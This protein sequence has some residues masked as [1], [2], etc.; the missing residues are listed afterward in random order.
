ML[1]GEM[2]SQRPGVPIPLC[3]LCHNAME[4]DPPTRQEPGA[5]GGIDLIADYV[6]RRR[7]CENQPRRTQRVPLK[8]R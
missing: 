3:D 1:G 4:L 5:D 2:V 6:C 7:G 8:T